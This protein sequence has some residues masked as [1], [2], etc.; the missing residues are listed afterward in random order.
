MR[1]ARAAAVVLI[2]MVSLFSCRRDP[3]TAKKH[4]FES[5][6][7]YYEKQRY[8]EAA[9]QYSNA[10]KIDG[11]YGPAYHKR[12]LAYLNY[13]PIPLM[14]AALRDFSRS[15]EMLKDN[16]AYKTEYLD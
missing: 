6:N 14:G 10:I 3:A 7:R 16:A 9:I 1:G 15:I 12:A 5:G 13:K 4:Y 2:S 11:R 8:K